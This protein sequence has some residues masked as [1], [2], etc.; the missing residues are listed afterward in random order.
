MAS[1][2]Y[3]P[4]GH[5]NHRAALIGR[6]EKAESSQHDF[7]VPVGLSYRPD[8]PPERM[9]SNESPWQ[10]HLLGNKTERRDVDPNSRDAR[11]LDCSRDVPDRH[12]AHGSDGHEQQHI[13]RCFVNH[14]DPARQGMLT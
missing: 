13:D 7:E 2:G 11:F 4:S 10:V 3:E 8:G 6:F 1:A 9:V 12:V 14:L 5:L